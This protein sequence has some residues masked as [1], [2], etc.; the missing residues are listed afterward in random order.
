MH[1][2]TVNTKAGEFEYPVTFQQFDSHGEMVEYY[3]NLGE[4]AKDVI[5]G[6][7][8]AAQKQGQTQGQKQ[9]VRVALKEGDKGKLKA[10]IADHQ[11]AAAVN[12]IGAPR[13]DTGGV[14]KKKAG[15]MGVELARKQAEKGEPLSSEEV[16]A[17]MAE[18]GL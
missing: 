5:L 7:V 10:A 14:T 1:S 12:V 8:N 15:E 3:T 13:T 17:I 6:I 4:N 16:T 2:K 9:G 18:H 11:K